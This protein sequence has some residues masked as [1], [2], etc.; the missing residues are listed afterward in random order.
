MLVVYVQVHVKPDFI[1]AFKAATL[2][3]AR[4][5]VLESGIAR[6]DVVQ[7]S[8]DPSRFVLIEAYLTSAAPALHKETAHYAAWRDAVAPMMATPRTSLRYHAVFPDDEAW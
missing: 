4:A 3:N 1:E 7:Q 2:A 8:D 6:F 5:S